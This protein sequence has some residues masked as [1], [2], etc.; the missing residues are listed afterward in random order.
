MQL[1]I[2]LSRLIDS[3]LLE[4]VAQL[5]KEYHLYE[6][7][8]TNARR[9]T[10]VCETVTEVLESKPTKEKVEKWIGAL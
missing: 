1:L 9:M 5:Q 4:G 10:K 2:L 8:M 7:A 6:I 3:R